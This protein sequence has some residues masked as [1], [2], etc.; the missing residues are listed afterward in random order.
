[1]KKFSSMSLFLSSCAALTLLA[2]PSAMA[3]APMDL[4]PKVR[5]EDTT[6]SISDTARLQSAI[7]KLANDHNINLY[8]VTVDKFESPQQS[9]AWAK[10]LGQMN[11]MGT[12]DVVLAIATEDRAATLV[13]GGE[14]TLSQSQVNDIY[15]NKVFPQLKKSDYSA[16]GIAAADGIAQAVSG[17]SR[18]SSS[19]ASGA[20]LAGPGTGLLVLG[21]VAAVAG[22]SAW[23]LG[24]NRRGRGGV[25]QPGGARP[26]PAGGAP[27]PQLR[28]EAGK[29][30]VST[31][32]AIVNS[33]QEVEFAALQYG[34]EAVAP[35]QKAI[36]DAK[37][38]MQR[39]FQL[40]KQLDD[41]IPD[42]EADQRAWLNEIIARCRDAQQAL[43]Q[44]EENFNNL[45]QLEKNAPEVL[46]SLESRVREVEQRIPAGQAS[47]D[48]MAVR[49]LPSA[50]ETVKDNIDQAHGRLEF[51]REAIAAARNLM[52]TN[53]SEAILEIRAGEEAAGQAHGLLESVDA[54][55]KELESAQRS[56]DEALMLA[57][58]DVA[59][60]RETAK[61]QRT[62]E[63][64][65]AAAGVT[66]VLDQI[67]AEARA[68]KTDPLALSRKLQQARSELDAALGSVRQEHEAQNSVRAS[69]Q[70]ALISAQAQVSTASQYIWARRGGVDSLARTK[71]REAERQLDF[72]QSNAQANP[73]EALTAANEAMRLATEAQ[74]IAQSDVDYFNR[75]YGHG[76]SHSNNSALLGGIL[77]GSILN[78]GF[79]G[80]HFSGGG[81]FGGGFGG[82]DFGG[83][84]F[85]GPSAGGTF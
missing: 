13:A 82:G 32:N 11:N 41:D 61:Y 22:G 51:A 16:A 68:S 57:Q 38:H 45:R 25:Q 85:D 4:P 46:T 74:E 72:A 37:E 52:D 49:Y 55:E 17:G 62:G 67:Q 34:S 84:G 5:V 21:G 76:Y 8:V 44:Q 78:G 19:Q 2:A 58:R 81:G 53:R 33:Q 28:Q 1:M 47:M 80:G 79:G 15:T 6:S 83:G 3:Q 43:Q 63:L 23:L 27:I 65:G 20:G 14:G 29:L 39:S 70:H 64:A 59:Q 56:L 71:L 30:L 35:Y 31:D 48:R 36:D 73:F 60:A 69:L 66:A 42:T 50:F 54:A 26:Q 40:Q 10:R 24:R 12:N 9:D 7:D 18:G 75:S 77:L